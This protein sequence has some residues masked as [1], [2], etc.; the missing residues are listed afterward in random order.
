MTARR[1]GALMRRHLADGTPSGSGT[2]TLAAVRRGV[3]T[4]P[5]RWL[6]A[7]T[8][9]LGVLAAAGLTVAVPRTS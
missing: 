1:T 2:A 9:L 8:L 7:I 4:G 6:V 3:A 5:R